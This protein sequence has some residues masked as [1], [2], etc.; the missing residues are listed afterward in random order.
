M[1]RGGGVPG[2][3]SEGGS[4]VAPD[5]IVSLIL[6]PLGAAGLA[7]LH[8]DVNLGEQEEL[9]QILFPAQTADV[10]SWVVP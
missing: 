3:I 1:R 2:P 5:R 9:M 10:H 6:G 7:E 8:P 4:G